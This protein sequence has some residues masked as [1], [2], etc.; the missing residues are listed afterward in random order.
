MKY[1]IM[2]SQ[3]DEKLQ[4]RSH[5]IISRYIQ[6]VKFTKPNLLTASSAAAVAGCNRQTDS[7]SAFL[8]A[9]SFPKN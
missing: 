9:N 5:N 7:F 6:N 1:H 8:V 3:P 4:E 2:I